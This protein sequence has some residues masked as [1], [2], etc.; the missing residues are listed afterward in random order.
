MRAVA[1]LPGVSARGLLAWMIWLTVHVYYL[2]GFENRAV[3][4][5]RWAYYYFTH[6]RGARIIITKE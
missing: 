3:V 6:G 1:D 2:I 4:L 5:L